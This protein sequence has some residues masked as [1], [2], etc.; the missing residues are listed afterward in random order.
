MTIGGSAAAVVAIV[1]IVLAIV[2]SGGNKPAASASSPVASSGSAAPSS[3]APPP[4]PP[5]H[6][7]GCTTKPSVVASPIANFPIIPAGIDPALK[8]EPT[9]TIP[10]GTV[11]ITLQTK[12]LIV[13]TGDTVGADD[14]VT[15][16]YLGVNYVDCTEFDSSWAHDQEATFS[17][18]GV[19][20]GFQQGVTGMKVG[21]RREIIIP[22]SLGYGASGS[23]SVGPNEELVFVVDVLATT[24]SSAAP[25]SSGA[26]NPAPSS[27]TK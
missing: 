26:P 5:T 27:S 17:L 6:A 11:P 20:P 22:P 10:A 19:V 24:H 7:D 25:T 8:T 9:I 23:G 16:N 1:A 14:T 2:L 18:S 12:D 3:S 4:P 21:G 15:I 13:G